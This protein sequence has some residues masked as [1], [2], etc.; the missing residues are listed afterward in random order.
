MKSLIK[1]IVYAVIILFPLFLLGCGPSFLKKKDYLP[2]LRRFSQGDPDGA[3]AKFPKGERDTFITNMEKA[4]LSLVQGR[5]E[6]ASLEKYEDKIESRLRYKV[7]GELKSFFYAETPEE[8]YASE[9]EIIWLH[10]LLSWGYSLRREYED[11]CVE[12]RKAAHLLTYT[13]SEEGHF[14]DPMLRVFLS[15]LWTMCGSWEDAAVDLRAAVMMD[16][17]LEWAAKLA[18]RERPP[19]HLIMILGGT[20]PE[21]G[22]NP[23]FEVIN[24]LRGM[25]HLR[26]I[27]Y[28][29]KS[30]ITVGDNEGRRIAAHLSP[31]AS[32]WYDRHLLRNH[33]IRELILDSRYGNR[34]FAKTAEGAGKISTGAAAGVGLGAAS[35]GTGGVLAYLGGK[36]GSEDLV[37]LGIVVAAAGV[38]QGYKIIKRTVRDAV[39]EMG[40]D[41]DPSERYRF[42]R[43]LPEYVWT[44]WS[45]DTLSYP[46]TVGSPAMGLSDIQPAVINNT[47][48]VSLAHIPDEPGRAEVMETWLGEF[49]AAMAKTGWEKLE[50]TLEEWY[51]RGAPYVM[52]T[53]AGGNDYKIINL[54]SQNR[55]KIVLK[56]GLFEK[57]QVLMID[58]ANR[59]AYGYTK[60]ISLILDEPPRRY[61]EAIRRALTSAIRRRR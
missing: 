61:F 29:K 40:M 49:E 8:Y 30:P 55:I 21:I 6:I 54:Y 43:F 48:V 35:V 10:L 11:A 37:K 22:W 28:G 59:A 14:D 19:R 2:S 46:L 42:V 25:R 13:W 60:D 52:M 51:G 50:H 41:I 18:E 45:D 26:F 53:T 32:N 20:G 34:I 27:F 44:A 1:P 39:H 57:D 9:H 56:R 36:A 3:L 23:E 31:D 24:P 4:Y 7:S 12:A 47:S 33:E 38:Y 17:S 16:E 58:I 15:G 5:P